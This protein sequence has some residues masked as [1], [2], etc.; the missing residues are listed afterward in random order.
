[1]PTGEGL[2]RGGHLFCLRF[3]FFFELTSEQ[4]SAKS[5]PG[6]ANRHKWGELSGCQEVKPMTN[7]SF[8]DILALTVTHCAHFKTKL[9]TSSCPVS[10][11]TTPQFPRSWSLQ[12]L[13]GS[14]I[15]LS[16]FC[17]SNMNSS[18]FLLLKDSYRH[19]RWLHISAA[20]HPTPGM[21]TWTFQL[22]M[23][24]LLHCE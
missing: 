11:L 18:A 3:F 6:R 17:K 13:P 5:F 23:M 10:S 16:Y 22:M 20:E 19:V 15:T 24:T 8:I 9:H 21:K 7:D 4:A 1:M 12:T 2:E 14:E